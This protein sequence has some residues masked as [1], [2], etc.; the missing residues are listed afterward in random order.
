MKDTH[1]NIRLSTELKES[2]E[3]LAFQNY[4]TPSEFAR[5]SLETIVATINNQ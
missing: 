1:L 5:F 2:I 3:E 4:I